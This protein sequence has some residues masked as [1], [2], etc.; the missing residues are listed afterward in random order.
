MGSGEI[1]AQNPPYPYAVDEDQERDDAAREAQRSEAEQRVC[2][3]ALAWYTELR[4]RAWA[5]QGDPDENPF[6]DEDT[7]PEFREAA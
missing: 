4:E 2:D 6:Q 1:A 3:E 7:V 5:A